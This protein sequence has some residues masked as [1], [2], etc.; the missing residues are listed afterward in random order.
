MTTTTELDAA[1]VRFPRPVK[2]G[3]KVRRGPCAQMLHFPAPLSGTDLH[4]EWFWLS[5]HHHNWNDEKLPE[6][7]DLASFD[8][9]RFDRQRRMHDVIR[10]GMGHEP[11]TDNEMRQDTIKWRAQIEKRVQVKDWL[12]S[13]GVN[14]K[15]V[16]HPES[17]L[18][19]AFGQ[20]HAQIPLESA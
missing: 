13:L 9:A 6:P 17:A 5:D 19:F 11:L 4:A 1:V 15:E 8:Q 14:W 10:Q 16:R 20:L 12:E 18:F 7:D 2:R 3:A